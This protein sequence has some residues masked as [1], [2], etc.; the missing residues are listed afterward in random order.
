MVSGGTLS[1]VTIPLMW[2]INLILPYYELH[3]YPI[4]HTV[5]SKDTKISRNYPFKYAAKNEIH[6]NQF[7]KSWIPNIC[8]KES[9][10][11]SLYFF[12]EWI[13]VWLLGIPYWLPLSPNCSIEGVTQGSIFWRGGAVGP[14][15]SPGTF[16]WIMS[17]HRIHW[18]A[19]SWKI[20]NK[21]SHG[22]DI[23]NE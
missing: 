14:S 13:P 10:E 18:P 12:C 16:P 22:K 2:R 9:Q 17:T 11:M 15:P 4:K 21:N 19:K 5:I 6:E 8:L 1:R 20:T 7:S 23:S 3:I